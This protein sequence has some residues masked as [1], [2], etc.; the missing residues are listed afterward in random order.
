MVNFGIQPSEFWGMNVSDFWL[1]LEEW[2]E[3]HCTSSNQN[4]LDD[5]DVERLK[6]LA[7]L[8]EAGGVMR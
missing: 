8:P 6:K 7:E 2:K 1:V 3:K 4:E 5:D